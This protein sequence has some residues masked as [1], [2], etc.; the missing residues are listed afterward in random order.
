MAI[1]KAAQLALKVLSLNE[2]DFTQNYKSVR[3]IMGVKGLSARHLK[4]KAQD[5]I[6]SFD[7]KTVPTR[8]YNETNTDDDRLIIYLHG[9]GWVTENIDTYHRTCKN[10]SHTLKI[11]VLSI[12]YRLAPEFP[13]PAALEDCIGVIRE[14]SIDTE[15]FGIDKNKIIL[16]GDS[17]GGNMSAAISIIA[18]S[19]PSITIN[20]QILLYPSVDAYHTDSEKFP[21]LKENATDYMLTTKHICEYAAL[22]ASCEE[23]YKNPLFAPILLSDFKN[24]PDTLVLTAQFDPLRDEGEY[25]AHALAQAGN[26]V[27]V[28]RI[29]DAIHGFFTHSDSSVNVKTAFKLIGQFLERDVNSEKIQNTELE[30]A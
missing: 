7:N 11:K 28:Y 21:S 14:I 6:F 19:N 29:L 12:E 2:I 13:F 3:S 23:D 4:G 5:F 26:F 25:Y 20:S 17:A 15:C 8:F 24:L 1:N 18:R 22:Y 27:R 9:G 30:Q 16:M 10:I